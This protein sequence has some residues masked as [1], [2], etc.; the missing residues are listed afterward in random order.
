VSRPALHRRALLRGALGAAIGLPFLNV[1]ARDAGAAPF[2][3]RLVIF[4]S[5]N[6]TI[7]EAWTPGGSEQNFTL[8]PILTPLAPYKE[9]ILV[10]DDVDNVAARNGPGDGHQTG[11]GC[12]LT[13]TELLEGTEFCEGDCS[14]PTQ[15]VG[16]G[17]GISVDQHIAKKVGGSTKFGSLE[18]G[19]QVQ[20]SDIWSAMSYAG[21]DQPIPP[22]DD[23]RQAFDRIFG[24]L[25]QD[26]LGLKKRK[27]MRRSVLDQVSADFR[28]L[29]ARLGAEDRKKL[30]NHLTSVR[31]IEKRLDAGG[32]LGGACELPSPGNIEDIYESENFPAIGKL[33]MDLLV[34]AL[35]CDL[36]RVTSIQWARSVSNKQFS[37]L[38]IPE[39]HHDL[40]HVGDSDQ[41]A[42][43]KLIKIN[44]WYAEQF[45]YLLGALDA[46][47]EGDGTLLDNT[48]VLWCNELG[49]GNSHTRDDIPFVLAGSCG[50]Y[51][52]TGRYLKYDGA[53]HNN[54]L[55]SLCHAM[56]VEGS[57][58]GNPAY[59]TGPLAN[60]T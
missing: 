30:A 26:P 32:E 24:E 35:A 50:G 20:S 11:M 45:A 15:T 12:M 51:F 57:S 22:E 7:P 42:R 37:W 31:E 59:C 5:A 40:S 58:F 47:P 23:P 55:L 38:G 53:P 49:V 48:A 19:V 39:G 14:D 21:P 2:P 46:V 13:G 44:T 9:K 17:G 29:D 60:L 3:K 18:F 54:L 43:N 41:N 36:T 25:T 27:D 10:L 34:M 33:Q 52:R 16:W 8:G 28:R 4:F 6:G 56:G 1:M